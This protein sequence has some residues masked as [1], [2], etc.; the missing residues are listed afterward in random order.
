[1][2][3]VEAPD[4]LRART[5]TWARVVYLLKLMPTRDP[6][7]TP[8]S[9]T[10][11]LSDRLY[12]YPEPPSTNGATMTPPT[13]QWLPLVQSWGGLEDAIDPPTGGVAVAAFDVT[14][15]N[16]MPIAGVARFSDLMRAG[17]N[18]T[19]YDFPFSPAELYQ[20]FE[21]VAQTSRHRLFRLVVEELT[22]ITEQRVTLKLSGIELVFEDLNSLPVID[23]FTFPGA[24]PEA[25][26]QTVP[27]LAGRIRNIPVLFTEAGIVDK[28]RLPITE[29]DPPAGGVLHLSTPDKVRRM[30]S[31]GVVQVGVTL[32]TASA[33][34]AHQTECIAY[35]ATDPVAA[36]LLQVTRGERDT[37]A[38]AAPAGTDV[39]QLIPEYIGVVGVNLGPQ[40]SQTLT[41]VYSDGMAKDAMAAP[42]HVIEMANTTYWPPYSL[43]L[44]RF[45]GGAMIPPW[46]GCAEMKEVAEVT[47]GCS[48]ADTISGDG[49][50]LVL[51][52]GIHVVRCGI[53]APCGSPFQ[54]FHVFM[55]FN[56][57]DKPTD[58]GAPVLLRFYRGVYP[59]TNGTWG[60]NSP[61]GYGFGDVMLFHV[62]TWVGPIGPIG[63]P[64]NILH[65]SYTNLAYVIGPG[66]GRE[67]YIWANVSTAYAAA[68]AAGN[69]T[70]MFG[71]R[72]EGIVRI[73]GVTIYQAGFFQDYISNWY[74]IGARGI[75]PDPLP[76]AP[77]LFLDLGNLGPTGAVQTRPNS[78][79]ASRTAAEAILGQVTVDVEGPDAPVA[80]SL[81]TGLDWR[82]GF[83]EGSIVL[84]GTTDATSVWTVA[85]A[86]TSGNGLSIVAGIHNASQYAIRFE[87][88][89]SLSLWYGGIVTKDFAS[90]AAGSLYGKAMVMGVVVPHGGTNAFEILRAGDAAHGYKLQVYWL[91]TGQYRLVHNT[92]SRSVDS[93]TVLGGGTLH[94]LEWRLTFGATGAV[95]LRIFAGDS[96]TPLE[97]LV[98]PGDPGGFI[99]SVSWL[100]TGGVDI[101]ATI[102][103]DD[104]GV[105]DQGWMGPGTNL[106]AV[107]TANR[108]VQ[109][110]PT[111]GTNYE[112]IDDH[113]GALNDSNYISA[114]TAGVIDQYAWTIPAAA[115]VP[116]TARV[117]RA[118]LYVRARTPSGPRTLIP[119]IWD[120]YGH[121]VTG[122]PWGVGTSPTM[123]NPGADQYTV[124]DVG[125][126]PLSTMLGWQLGVQLGTG[127]VDVSVLYAVLEYR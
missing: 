90:Y 31:S 74:A 117:Y 97:T 13:E 82:N 57:A 45:E 103:M 1:V 107:P 95:E 33:L 56:I 28:L 38:G 77:A 52:S 93:A 104:V 94:R 24:A 66:T 47:D 89:G 49:S 101:T 120:E 76:Y 30:P 34:G 40:A 46:L 99:N 91:S 78:G 100:G 12:R 121:L 26:G 42:K 55:R 105:S 119:I 79:T 92:A 43:T 60:G 10:L 88:R 106:I 44:V 96:L 125:G 18:E 69:N 11:R 80:V 62:P 109:W 25:V 16:T 83:E 9:I 75:D 112:C 20:V 114:T 53:D 23:T 85:S 41:T 81:V 124:Y 111:G 21:G 3:F 63:S 6:F 37:L 5:R 127:P 123:I 122:E 39:Y 7:T 118:T 58:P 84:S 126:R 70:L 51:A 36:D 29:K 116:S 108:S 50:Q 22:P 115:V 2:S 67:Q 86:G 14:L 19:G 61:P 27:W 65:V 68:K 48:G 32:K 98:L 17:R 73:G 4:A 8:T 59:S 72:I 102:D 71:L 15:D 110:I 35:G 87:A 64:T 113:P 54:H